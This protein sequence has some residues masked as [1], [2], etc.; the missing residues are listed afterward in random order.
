MSVTNL[1]AKA[2]VMSI[3]SGKSNWALQK[4]EYNNKFKPISNEAFEEVIIIPVFSL[5]IHFI[6][7]P[8]PTIL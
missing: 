4:V 7:N 2:I 5:E 1:V 8:L 6:G 3:L